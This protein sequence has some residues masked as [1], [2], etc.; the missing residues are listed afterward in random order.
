MGVTV[1]FRNGMLTVGAALALLFAPAKAGHAWMPDA[2]GLRIVPGQTVDACIETRGRQQIHRV[3][4][5]TLLAVGGAPAAGYVWRLSRG[6]FFPPGT[7]VDPQTGVF[8]AGGGPLSPGIHE[9]AMT[10]TD[11]SATAR[12]T[13]VLAVATS[14]R[15]CPRVPLRQRAE[16]LIELPPAKAGTPY[17]ASLFAMGGVPPYR[18]LEDTTAWD[19]G[20]LASWGFVVDSERGVVRGT[21]L[22]VLAGRILR[23]RVQV[24]DATDATAAGSRSGRPPTYSISVE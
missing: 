17:G 19:R 16:R 9:F 18:W 22:P 12:E 11:G 6:S 3:Y 2:T 7:T 5:Q 1:M 10:V 13:I 8:A 4:P 15:H 14:D 24:K 23:F 20:Q 21:P